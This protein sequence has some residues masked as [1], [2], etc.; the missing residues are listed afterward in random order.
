MTNDKVK[1]HLWEWIGT[2]SPGGTWQTY[3]SELKKLAADKQENKWWGK[4]MQPWHFQGWV[5]KHL[6]AKDLGRLTVHFILFHFTRSNCI[7]LLTLE[8]PQPFWKQ[9]RNSSIIYS[10]HASKCIKR[11]L[12]AFFFAVPPAQTAGRQ[13]QVKPL[14]FNQV[15]HY[16]PFHSWQCAMN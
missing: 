1:L 2:Y 11:P 5:M 3:L 4:K 10:I 15:Y 6:M 8:W 13:R 9:S 14:N 12:K 7:V 16:L